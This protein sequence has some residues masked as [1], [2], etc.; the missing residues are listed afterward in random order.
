MNMIS[1][2]YTVD[3]S[4]HFNAADLRPGEVLLIVDVMNVVVFDQGENAAK[5]SDDPRLAAVVNVASSHDM[6]ADGLFAP[7]LIYRLH[8]AVALCLGPVF[9]FPFE[10]FVVIF[11]LKIFSERNA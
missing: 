11:R 6:R 4:V 5:M 10:P 7:A 8:D 3:R 9:V 1:A 2:E